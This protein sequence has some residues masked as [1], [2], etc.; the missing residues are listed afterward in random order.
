[1]SGQR[2]PIE[3]LLIKGNKHL[4]KDEVEDRKSREIRAPSDKVRAPSYLDKDMKKE[5]TKI[6]KELVEVGIMT[7]LDV[8]AL[9]RFILAKKMYL[10][11]TNELLLRN[12]ITEIEEEVTEDGGTVRVTQSVSGTYLELLQAQDK[13][14]KQ[15]R[16]SAA[17][18]GLTISSRCR[19]VV[20]KKET[21]QEKTEE[22]KLFGDRV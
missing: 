19:L 17:D 21:K 16:Q 13:L 20:P 11:I 5:F 22:E 1:M 7:N 15:C 12:P 4:T 9:A 14:F 2:Q 3:L 8:D 10:Q 6:S 18:L